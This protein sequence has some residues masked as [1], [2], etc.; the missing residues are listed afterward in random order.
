MS[1]PVGT[2]DTRRLIPMD[3][4]TRRRHAPRR[5]RGYTREF[6]IA[7]HLGRLTTNVYPDG[8]L[9][10]VWA[11]I[12]PAPDSTWDHQSVNGFLSGLC[13][14]VT[15]GLQHGVSLEHYVRQYVGM[16]FAPAGPV[17]DPDIPRA[18]SVPDYVFRRIALD[19][20]DFPTRSRLG[21]RSSGEAGGETSA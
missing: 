10:E 15:L 12:E 16:S 7:G 9:G 2:R 20:L 8:A 3:L 21:I 18:L 6:T 14:A 17:S 19:H 5:R 11:G 4:G 1:R 13:S